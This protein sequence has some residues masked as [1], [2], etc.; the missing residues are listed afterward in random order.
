MYSMCSN[1]RFEQL[2]DGATFL[3]DEEVYEKIKESNGYNAVAHGEDF[4][5]V[6]DDELVIPF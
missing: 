6:D 2:R 1:F 5:K 3:Y 4:I